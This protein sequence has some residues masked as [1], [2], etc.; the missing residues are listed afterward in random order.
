MKR[1][2]G[3]SQSG[4]SSRSRR[5]LPGATAERESSAHGAP[6][7][8]DRVDGGPVRPIFGGLTT[9]ASDPVIGNQESILANQ[10][11]IL[12]NQESIEKNQSKL[13]K[14]VANQA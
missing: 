11:K 13:D 6:T 3:P 12:A 7:A 5:Y 8:N 9:M 1:F 14:I 10:E 2:G 4:R